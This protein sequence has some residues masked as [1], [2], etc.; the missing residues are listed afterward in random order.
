MGGTPAE[1]PGVYRKANV[2][3]DVAG[4]E[5]P[6]AVM[7]GAEDPQVPPYGS[8]QFVKALSKHGKTHAYFTYSGEPRGFRKSEHRIDT[9]T[10]QLAFLAKY[11]QPEYGRAITSTE[12]LV[13]KRGPHFR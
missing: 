9:W 12:E 13:L 2:L 11:L 5:T 3:L 1:K 6:L 7:H 8:T 4:I 10:K